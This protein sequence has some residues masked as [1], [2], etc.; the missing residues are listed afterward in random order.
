MKDEDYGTDGTST[1]FTLVKGLIISC[2]TTFHP[3]EG[4]QNS[5]RLAPILRVTIERRDCASVYVRTCVTVA[6]VVLNLGET[7]TRHKNG[8]RR[9]DIQ[10]EGNEQSTEGSPASRET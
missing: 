5:S 9:G 6:N 1:E 4:A 3:T 8:G 10:D 2:V 7:Q